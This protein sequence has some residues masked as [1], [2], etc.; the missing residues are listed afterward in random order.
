MFDFIKLLEIFL[1]FFICILLI[2]LLVITVRKNK[3]PQLP[4]NHETLRYIIS[5][6]LQTGV[7]NTP[8]LYVELAL[9]LSKD[10]GELLNVKIEYDHLSSSNHKTFYI[11][12]YTLKRVYPL[13]FNT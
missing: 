11:K 1:G 13:T 3:R 5:G 10:Y 4:P 7:Y 9:K 12:D 8:D 2:V 6:A